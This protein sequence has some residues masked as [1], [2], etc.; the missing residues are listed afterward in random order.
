MLEH[1]TWFPVR[2]VNDTTLISWNGHCS[3]IF[4]IITNTVLLNFSI[5]PH[6]CLLWFSPYIPH[7]YVPINTTCPLQ[8]YCRRISLRKE[9]PWTTGNEPCQLKTLS[10]VDGAFAVK[11]TPSFQLVHRHFL[12]FT[13][14]EQSYSFSA[15]T[16][17]K[18]WREAPPS[19]C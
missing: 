11:V 18:Q 7:F 13:L 16:T 2:D 3:W 17:D 1:C 14:K 9:V 10:K 4:P 6:L 12:L 5:R 15:I 19:F 8:G